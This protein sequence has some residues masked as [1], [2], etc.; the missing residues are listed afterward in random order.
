MKILQIAAQGVR[1]LSG[2]ARFS[3]SPKLTAITASFSRELASLLLKSLFPAEPCSRQG[4]ND[5]NASQSPLQIGF[6]FTVEEADH[7]YYASNLTSGEV[8]LHSWDPETGQYRLLS[9]DSKEIAKTFS[10]RFGLEM[11][12]Y[13]NLFTLDVSVPTGWDILVNDDGILIFKQDKAA[14]EEDSRKLWREKLESR[15]DEAHQ[16]LFR[17][18]SA[19]RK[20]RKIKSEIL[21]MREAIE[22]EEAATTLPENFEELVL[23]SKKA[24]QEWSERQKHN[25][26]ELNALRNEE[27]ALAAASLFRDPVFMGG[28]LIG[29]GSIASAVLLGGALRYLALGNIV[30]FGI[31]AIAVNAYITRRERRAYL[32]RRAALLHGRSERQEREFKEL[33]EPVE[34]VLQKLK[35]GRVE[36]VLRRRAAIDEMRRQLA[37][38][39]ALLEQEHARNQDIELN[40]RAASLADEITRLEAQLM[41]RENIPDSVREVLGARKASVMESESATRYTL[42]EDGAGDYS[43]LICTAAGLLGLLPD[44]VIQAASQPFGEILKSLSEGRIIDAELSESTLKIQT[45][46]KL[47]FRWQELGGATRKLICTA[48]KLSLLKLVTRESRPPVLVFD[49]LSMVYGAAP[50]SIMEILVELARQVQIISFC[51]SP[52]PKSY[53][54]QVVRV[55]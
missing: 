50:E 37:R 35:V 48:L 21:T 32:K 18:E 6:Q 16:E 46:D 13:V 42:Q 19:Q 7:Y 1:G 24:S 2:P 29:A 12:E 41:E 36:E 5:D 40:E 43:G 11:L 20:I 47:W 55:S 28:L 26:D 44:A 49:P 9:S 30:G 33:M 34:S 10:Q 31:S 8:F 15:L 39:Q 45:A 3:L 38:N 54:A 25:D 17:I 22:R 53:G 14:L 52:L 4:P 27:N 51:P 23:G